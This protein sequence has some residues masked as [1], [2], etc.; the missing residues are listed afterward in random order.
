MKSE[1]DPRD[2]LARAAALVRLFCGLA[3]FGECRSVMPGQVPEP[4]RT[5]LDHRSHMT[6]AMERFHGCDVRLRVVAQA[7]DG[8]E[9]G[10][11]DGW[12]A[13]EILLETPAGKIVQYGIVRIDLTHLD[14]P[15]ARAIREGRRPLGRILIEAGM[16]R[17]VQGVKLLEIMPG[18]HLQ[19]LFRLTAPRPAGIA[20]TAGIAP[21]TGIAVGTVVYGRVADIQLDGRPAVELLE[22]VAPAAGPLG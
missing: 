4:A 18:P 7:D 20:P 2:P 17:D 16:L 6:V 21:P 10:P 15:T 5:L 9:H 12:Y 13:R 8:R 22:I 11:N 14:A 3:D 1:P 19:E